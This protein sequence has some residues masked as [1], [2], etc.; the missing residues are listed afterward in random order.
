[1]YIFRFVSKF[2]KFNTRFFLLNNLY[3][4]H[5]F[6]IERQLY[7]IDILSSD[8]YKITYFNDE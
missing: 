8:L 3:L 5:K 7:L 2:C 4:N 6:N 1:M